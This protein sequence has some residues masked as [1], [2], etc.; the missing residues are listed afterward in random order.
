MTRHN[1]PCQRRAA[2]PIVCLR[3]G[4]LGQSEPMR[5]EASQRTNKTPQRPCFIMRVGRDS[6][7]RSTLERQATFT[8][9]RHQKVSGRVGIDGSEGAKPAS[10]VWIELIRLIPH[11]QFKGCLDDEFSLSDLDSGLVVDSETTDLWLG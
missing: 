2:K 8:A 3:P 9:D 10:V 6:E 4:V 11:G 7:S 5:L 1:H